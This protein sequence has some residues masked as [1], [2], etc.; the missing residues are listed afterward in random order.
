MSSIKFSFCVHNHQPVGNFDHVFE[1][2]FQNAYQP[3]FQ[4]LKTFPSLKTAAHFSGPLLEWI[5][6]N[7][8][9]FLN[10]L[11]ELVQAGRL[12]LLGGGFYEPILSILP[13]HDAVGQLQMMNDFLEQNIGAR[14]RGAW[15]TERIWE[16]EI[17]EILSAAGLEYT[18]VDDAH[19]HYAGLEQG[20]LD[21]Y[22]ITEH[23]GVALKVFPIQKNLRYAIPFKL[24]EETLAL[25]REA[26]E[27]GK[28]ALVYADDGEKF[29]VW[30]ETYQ[31]VYEEEWLK[32]FF[33]A[34]E[35]NQDWL[36]TATFS[37]R[38]DA[39]PPTD[40]VYLPPASYDEMMEWA[41][42]VSAG[43]RLH[44]VKEDLQSRPDDYATPP[45]LSCAAVSGIIF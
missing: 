41:L 38:L 4:I 5:Q 3:Y 39:S 40:R 18:V 7:H 23:K 10:L 1:A 13:T 34:L 9:D 32:R 26:A 42:P 14:P 8:P 12:E 31:W 19:F 44:A 6:K 22:Y 45:C 27:S 29:G 11:R 28:S 24:P 33:L 30:P 35:D 43:K 20:S 16:P 15:L 25:F 21:G 2:C 17:P 37:E 36:Q